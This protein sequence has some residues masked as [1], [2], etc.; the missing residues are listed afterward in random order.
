MLSNSSCYAVPHN[1]RFTLL[2]EDIS[3]L[4]R[5]KQMFFLRSFLSSF[6]PSSY[7][8]VCAFISKR[9]FSP[10]VFQRLYTIKPVTGS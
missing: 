8:L 5:T 10:N 6:F 4:F 9:H 7:A 1:N 3:L 2:L